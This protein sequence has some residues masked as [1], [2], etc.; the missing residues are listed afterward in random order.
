MRML[1]AQVRPLSVEYDDPTRYPAAS[2][3]FVSFHPTKTVPDSFQTIVGSTCHPNGDEPSVILM[4]GSNGPIASGVEAVARIGA[5]RA[6][7]LNVPEV[8]GTKT[9]D[10]TTIAISRTTNGRNALP[11]MVGEGERDNNHFAQDRLGRFDGGCHPAAKIKYDASV[12]NDARL[13]RGVGRPLVD[14]NRPH[15]AVTVGGGAPSLALVRMP[16][17]RFCPAGLEATGNAAGERRSP[18]RSWGTGQARK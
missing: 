6:A 2:G 9:I 16:T 17:L 14:P 18:S 11:R 3:P 1:L 10:V 12:E 5:G 8:G 7:T 4:F 13:D 15:G